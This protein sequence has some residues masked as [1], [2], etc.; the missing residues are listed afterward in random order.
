[1]TEPQL[2]SEGNPITDEDVN[3]KMFVVVRN[4]KSAQNNL[5]YKLNKGDVIKLGRIKFNV[6]DYR[7]VFVSTSEKKHSG[8][9]HE[10]EKCDHG[11][12]PQKLEKKPSQDSLS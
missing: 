6:K 7:S 2:D 3:N 12:T 4:T 5:D 10:E 1:V 8:L 9:E 11:C